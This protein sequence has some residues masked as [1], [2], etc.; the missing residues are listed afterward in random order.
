MSIASFDALFRPRSIA[1]IGASPQPQSVGAVLARNLRLG[2]F[3]GPILPVNPRHASIGGVL[4]YPD[5]A[6]LPQVPDLAVI[7]TPP[8]TVPELVAALGQA[9]TKAAVV[10]TAG[11]KELGSAEGRALEETM[12]AAAKPHGLR[13]V[14]PNCVGVISTPMGINAS[15]VHLTPRP[16]R[17]AFVTQSGAM[18]TTVLDWAEAR[19]IGFSHM[20]SLGDMADVD[21]GDMLDYLAQ[22]TSTDAILLYIE[23]VTDAKSFLAAARRAARIKPVIAI[24]AGRHAA[25]AKA[26]TSHTGAL[27]GIDGVYD[28]AFQRAGILRVYTL[29]E[30]FDAVET[31]AMPSSIDGD[32]LAILT[33]GGGVGVLAT[34]AL[35]DQGGRLAELAPETIAGL[36]QVLP[37]TWSHGNPVDII[38]DAPGK[39]YADALQ[40]LLGAPEVDAVLVLNCPTAVASGL[41]AAEAVAASAEARPGRVLANWLGSGSGRAAQQLFARRGI[42]NF[43]TPENAV[44]GFMHRVHFRSNQALLAA[45]MPDMAPAPEADAARLLVAKALAGAEPGAPPRWLEDEAIRAIFGLYGIPTVRSAN[46]ADPAE[47]ATYARKIGGLFALKIRSPDIT[48]KSDVGGVVLNIPAEEMAASAEAMLAHIRRLAPRASISGFTVQEMIRRP[49]AYELIVGMAVDRQF[50]PFLL[51]GH[52]GVAVEVMNDK[53][54][55]LPP[56]DKAAAH[57]LITRTRIWRELRGFRHRPP[58]AIDAIADVLQKLSRLVCDLDEITELDI[59]PLLADSEGVIALDAR[60]RVAHFQE[61]RG[62]RLALKA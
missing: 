19:E 31:L 53:A 44:R 58:A 51:F 4:A 61:P 49:D 12:L 40:C 38:G 8:A 46:V 32:R 30:V 1:L 22:D 26:A 42:P 52:G 56:L 33:N 2:G 39:R 50:G 3:E 14:G 20:V 7:C 59:N 60:I 25:A 18:L 55:A 5:V 35:M 45:P 54:L 37:P 21:F 11:F 13:I 57:D 10:I 28:A 16:G 17:L 62:A 34:D 6:H 27:A 9:G 15:F 36:N 43:D 48:H 41:D 24:K 23:A 29:D 47:A